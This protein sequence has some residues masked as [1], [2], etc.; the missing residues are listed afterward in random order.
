MAAS[1]SSVGTPN[2]VNSQPT[3]SGLE[4]VAVRMADPHHPGQAGVLE[5]SVAFFASQKKVGRCGV[6][7]KCLL[8]ERDVFI[9]EIDPKTT[10]SHR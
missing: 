7:I 2:C 10:V 1:V 6:L 8:P 5:V 4:A 9:T 3:E